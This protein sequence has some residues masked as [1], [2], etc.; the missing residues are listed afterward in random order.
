MIRG[1]L[2]QNKACPPAPLKGGSISDMNKIFLKNEYGPPFRG[3]GG[4]QK[5]VHNPSGE[6]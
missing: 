2:V 6:Q 5:R 1:H 3:V 4:M